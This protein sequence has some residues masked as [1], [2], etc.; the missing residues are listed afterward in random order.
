MAS[1]CFGC[2]AVES[3]I[4]G[5]FA[6]YDVTFANITSSMQNF[7]GFSIIL[8]ILWQAGKILL[9]FSPAANPV[10]SVGKNSGV[11]LNNLVAKLLLAIAI[12]LIIPSPKFYQDYLFYPTISTTLNLSKLLMETATKISGADNPATCTDNSESDK[13]GADRESTINKITN[14]FSCQISAVQRQVLRGMNISL[15]TLGIGALNNTNIEK[16]ATK[17][18][19]LFN[20]VKNQGSFNFGDMLQNSLKSIQNSITNG[21]EQVIQASQNI[22]GAAGAL[23]NVGKRGGTLVAD[24]L[25]RIF[26]ALVLL[27]L[28]AFVFVMYPLLNLNIIMKWVLITIF[29]PYIAFTA[30]YNNTRVAFWNAVKAVLHGVVMMMFL[31]AIMGLCIGIFD[32]V[33]NDLQINKKE[34]VDYYSFEYWQLLLGALMMRMLMMKSKEYADEIVKSQWDIDVADS[35]LKRMKYFLLKP[36]KWIPGVGQGAHF[37]AS[38]ALKN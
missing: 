10:V 3:Y 7:I 15:K 2:V 9:P 28:F 38:T 33:F 8:Y 5:G 27:Y 22:T 30:I 18:G 1:E 29:W 21:V 31:S 35:F 23:L 14:T 34:G 24:T 26:S 4:K 13:K 6:L 36:I 32:Q 17:A 25:L 20:T 11:L 12:L 37:V 16:V 19:S